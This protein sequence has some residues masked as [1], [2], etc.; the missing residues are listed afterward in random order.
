M[1]RAL[2]FVAAWYVALQAE[3]AG[4]PQGLTERAIVTVS[5]AQVVSAVKA[6]DDARIARDVATLV[7]FG[8]RHT[9]SDTLSTTRGIGAARRWIHA[10]FEDAAA[11]SGGR[12][13]VRYHT[14]DVPVPRL[15]RPSVRVVN[16][17]ATLPGD[18][19]A[20]HT[21][22]I[23]AHYDS[24]GTALADSTGAAPGADDDASGVAV[25]LEAARVLSTK[26]FPATIV[27]AA[28]AG[29][30]QG[31]LGSDCLAREMQAAGV[32]IGGMLANDIV[33]GIRGQGGTVDSTRL[34]V[35]SPDPHDSPSRELARYIARVAAGFAP[36]LAPR[37]I[38]RADRIGRGSDHLSFTT[39]GWAAVRFCEPVED[40]RHQHQTP[41]TEN[42]V[43]YGD[44]AEHVSP[45]F[46]AQVARVNVGTIGDLASAPVPPDSAQ[47]SGTA[48]PDVHVRWWAPNDP[49][50]QGFKVMRRSTTSA[51]WQAEWWV[52]ERTEITLPN[53]VID[54]NEF[55]VVAVGR[56]AESVAVPVRLVR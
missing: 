22:V 35:F 5:P 49:R 54:D 25:M 23:G 33:G 45:R 24:R 13:Q 10:Q 28:F 32:R 44:L 51:V 7:S 15:G 26:R 52:G 31:L 48:S 30:E 46:V 42:G 39:R 29:E 3:A 36:G 27:F 11:A 14:C 6:I 9:L 47:A 19:P 1:R 34:R 2:T 55:A 12:L 17:I 41:R 4:A 37:L 18:D 53:V 56:D 50:R 16:V 21:Y 20:A 43:T 40:Y 8:T 38:A